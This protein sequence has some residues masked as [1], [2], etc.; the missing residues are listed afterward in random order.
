MFRINFGLN[1]NITNFEL[2]RTEQVELRTHFKKSGSSTKS[3]LRTL[4]NSSK[5][6]KLQTCLARNRPNPGP[7]M[8]KPN[9]EPLQTQVYLPKSNSEPS[10][11]PELQTNE[12]DSTQHYSGMGRVKF[13][14][15]FF[16]FARFEVQF[17]W[18][19]N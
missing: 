12:L 7:N 10:K 15:R 18:R 4:S 16:V 19:S 1:P 11:N 9:F 17:W 6:P 5:K 8:E 13:V 3:E 14:F 2:L